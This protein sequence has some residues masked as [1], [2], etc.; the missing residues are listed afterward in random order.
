M[1]PY[2]LTFFFALN[3]AVVEQVIW[4][5]ISG[6]LLC[7]IFILG[8][9]LALLHLPGS[10]ETKRGQRAARLAAAWVL[11]L[12]AA[13][14]YEIGQFYALLAGAFLAAGAYR[15]GRVGR[16]AGHFALFLSIS[17][18]Y[19]AVNSF[20]WRLHQSQF[21]EDVSLT[22][23]G[24]RCLS[25]A[26][27]EHLARYVVFTIV[28]P[29]LPMSCK[30][31]MTPLEDRG[32]RP[33][34]GKMWLGEQLWRGEL[35]IDGPLVLSLLVFILWIGLTALG[36]VR[37]VKAGNKKPLAVSLLAWG[38]CGLHV[39]IIVI[40]RMNM[41]RDSLLLTFNP[42]YSYFTL[43]FA[44]IGSLP[45][46]YRSAA[47]GPPGRERGATA[48]RLA[49]HRAGRPWRVR[50]LADAKDQP[51]GGPTLRALPLVPRGVADLRRRPPGRGR[52][53]PGDRHAPLGQCARHPRPTLGHRL[54]QEI[55][56]SGPARSTSCGGKADG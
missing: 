55:T 56:S 11:T 17:L 41:R 2:A 28:Q 29:F 30:W 37:L 32:A 51:E 23:I 49:P 15:R 12:L 53:Q 48:R 42:Y 5:N 20:D 35:G 9:L 4:F 8:S 3:Y 26:S 33:G 36:T 25:L 54:L 21:V 1:L 31:Q 16:A 27:L 47:T 14:T 46:C 6:Y 24:G 18:V 45:P 52:L 44:L 19:Q 34:V 50:G 40:G 7:I 38:V 39:G 13:F 22:D 43:L 10:L